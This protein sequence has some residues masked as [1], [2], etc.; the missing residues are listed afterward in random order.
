MV[1]FKRFVDPI[2]LPNGREL[3]TLR[4]AAEYI[5]TLPKADTM[6]PIGK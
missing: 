1:W 3:L 4:D 2:I 5:T 6:P